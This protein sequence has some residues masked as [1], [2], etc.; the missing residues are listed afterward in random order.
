LI[1]AS[2]HHTY[3]LPVCVT[4]CGNLFGGGDLNFSRIVPGTI[5]SVLQGERPVIRSDGSP[6]RDYV[7][8]KDIALAYMMLAEAMEEPAIRGEAFNF[9]TCEPVTV[10]E[11]TKMI[12]RAAGRED[13][14]P[15]VLNQVK[16][17]IKH[18]YLSSEKAR[19]LLGWEPGEPLEKRLSETVRWYRDYFDRLNTGAAR[20]TV[21]P[22]L[23]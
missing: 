11:L 8:I 13:L 22:A 1:A 6:I 7:H 16:G 18:Q 23:V 2:Y 17:E 15:Q 21:A 20:E 3:Q 19:K 4:R 5:C 14:E 9:G 12:L 10:L